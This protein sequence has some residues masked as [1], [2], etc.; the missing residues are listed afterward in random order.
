MQNTNPATLSVVLNP[1]LYEKSS[2]QNVERSKKRMKPWLA[3][4]RNCK[5][6]EFLSPNTLPPQTAETSQNPAKPAFFKSSLQRIVLMCPTNLGVVCSE[7]H[8]KVHCFANAFYD[9]AQAKTQ[10]SFAQQFEIDAMP[11]NKIDFVVLTLCE[12]FVV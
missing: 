6:C 10:L 4:L 12:S 9:L 8:Q 3:Q 1:S 11:L 7:F 2:K 5:A